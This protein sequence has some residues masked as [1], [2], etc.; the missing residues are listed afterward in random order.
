V[1]ENCEAITRQKKRISYVLIDKEGRMKYSRI[2]FCHEKISILLILIYLVFSLPAGCSK[3]QDSHQKQNNFSGQKN[4]VDEYAHTITINELRNHV[5]YLSSDEM[6]G[7]QSGS[8]GA[9]AAADYIAKNFKEA[10]LKGF[11]NGDAPYFQ[12][13]DMVKKELMECFLENEHG[14]AKNWKDF[15]EFNS[16]FEGEKEIELHLLGYGRQTDF[17]DVNLTGKLVAFF[18]SDP[19]SSESAAFLD[20][21]KIL[22]AFEREAAGYLMITSEEEKFLDYIRRI[23]PYF[24]AIRYY[25]AITSAQALTSKRKIDI[26]PSF[27]AKLFGISPADLDAVAKDMQYGKVERAY[28]TKLRMKTRYKRHG[29]V[30]TENVLGYFE[31]TDKKD[32]YIILTGHYD[33]RGMDGKVVLNG[34]ND[35]ATGVAAIIEIAE[36]FATAIQNGHPPRRSIIFM[37]PTAEELLA[38]G[39]SFYVENPVVPLYKT[40]VDIN[41]DPLGREDADSL[42]LKNHVYVYCSKNGREDLLSARAEIEKKFA[43]NLRIAE[44]ERYGGSDNTIFESSGIPALAYTTGKSKDNHGP[45]DDPDKVQYEK[46]EKVTRLIF[47]TVWEIANREQGIKKMNFN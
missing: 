31:G 18:S 8:K 33:G 6:E 23:K 19:E 11:F 27:V 10:K 1:G 29:V 32:E 47:R 24:P 13:F 43:S 34:A 17:E 39:S 36:A 15:L 44:K 46:L 3:K 25:Q 4:P 20:R 2:V 42:G 21:L 30:P 35:N 26:A 5:Y 40:I 7:R 45:G 41:M 14:R 12:K 9:K 22:R 38:V 37:M 28:R 16:D